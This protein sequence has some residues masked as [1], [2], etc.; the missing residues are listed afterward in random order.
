MKLTKYSRKQNH[1]SIAKLLLNALEQRKQ[2]LLDNPSMACAVI[3]DPRF[4]KGLNEQ[5]KE[6]AISSLKNVWH[7][8]KMVSD[9]QLNQSSNRSLADMDISTDDDISIT[10]S[11]TTMLNQYLSKKTPVSNQNSTNIYLSSTFDEV[12]S[13]LN[14]FISME[15]E[16]PQTN[17]IGFWNE[18][19]AKF[20]DLYELSRIVY[21]IAPTQAVVERAFS[22]LAYV[23]NVRR[24]AMNP[25]MLE[26]I[27]IISLNEDLFHQVN[28][29][30]LQKSKN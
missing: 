4:C 18:N 12:I 29:D 28:N 30:D 14:G 25:Q 19:K 3:L 5:Q 24:N 7:R 2:S 10:I 22:S 27:L 8:M 13:S 15:H 21:A 26:D 11:N 9:Q 23:Y 6:I 1:T 20:P 17:I 16:M